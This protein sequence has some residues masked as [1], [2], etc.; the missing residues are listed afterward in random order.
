MQENISKL[1]GLDRKFILASKSPRRKH[2][3]TMLGFKFDI[4]PAHIDETNHNNLE[5]AEYVKTLALEKAKHIAKDIEHPSIIM[6]ADT[7]V[8]LDGEMLHKPT[9]RDDA[10][11]ILKTLSGNTHTVHTGVALVSAPEMKGIADV[12]STLVTFRE[13]DDKEIWAYIDGGSP[14]DKA[15]AY[16]IQ[17]DFG[18]LFVSRI[19]GCYYNIVGLPLEM[20]Y[21]MMKKFITIF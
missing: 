21:S 4:I 12:K 18:A 14:M 20:L 5:S 7:T 3:L 19:E 1:I 16:G 11:R 2:L 15:G 9:D 8:V 6:G 10:F 13:L 17:D